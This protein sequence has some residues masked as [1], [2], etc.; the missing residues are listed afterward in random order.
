MEMSRQS[1]LA[2]ALSQLRDQVSA[3]LDRQRPRNVRHDMI[4]S[5]IDP[6]REPGTPELGAASVD[7]EQATP[8]G[9]TPR[10]KNAFLHIEPPPLSR[11]VGGRSQRDLQKLAELEGATGACAEST[12]TR[13]L[14]RRTVT[15][16]MEASM[17]V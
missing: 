7:E 4:A 15:K 9:C 13:L 14:K 17:C 5:V 12:P 1:E 8:G 2:D 11:G 6:A 10:A 3:Q 16:R